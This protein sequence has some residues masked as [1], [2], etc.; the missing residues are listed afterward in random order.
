MCQS[1]S[2]CADKILTLLSGQRV[3]GSVANGRWV[4]GSV[5]SGSMGWWLIGFMVAMFSVF[6]QTQQKETMDLLTYDKGNLYGSVLNHLSRNLMRNDSKC[7]YIKKTSE[8]LVRLSPLPPGNPSVLHASISP[9]PSSFPYSLPL[10][11]STHL[12]HTVS[13]SHPRQGELSIQDLLKFGIR[14]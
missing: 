10:S 3:S 13:T 7:T 8:T 1:S 2:C 14:F 11:P 9:V 6:S 5:V 4:S 12:T